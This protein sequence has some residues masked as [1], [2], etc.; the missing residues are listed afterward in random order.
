MKFN[1]VAPWHNTFQR[2]LFLESWKINKIP[3]WLVLQQDELKE[4]CARTK[5]KGIQTAI[6]NGAEMIVVLDDDCFPL[7][8]QTLESFVYEHQKALRPQEVEM[9]E[10]I[11]NPQS[12]GTPFYNRTIKM[13]VAAAMGYWESI[14]DFDAV[15]QLVHQNV[16]MEHKQKSMF[17]KYFAFSGMNF[18]FKIDQWP[19]CQLINV[20]RFDDIW[21]G[22]LWQKVAYSKGYCFNLSAPKVNHIRQ[23]NVWKNLTAEVK[24]LEANET[25]WT[26]IHTKEIN[27]Y[28]DA[29]SIINEIL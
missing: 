22:L 9:F 7:N 5:N 29:L 28:K 19:W 14:P 25:L 23:S 27:N 26:T 15:H 20:E 4:G 18:S 10:V 13:P 24:Y 21:M 8:D 12:R 3:D 17:G 6:A 2:D 1:V 16:Q 11:T